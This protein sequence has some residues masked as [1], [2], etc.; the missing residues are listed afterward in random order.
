[1]SR[2]QSLWVLGQSPLNFFLLIVASVS[3]YEA[4]VGNRARNYF[5]E[6]R[7]LQAAAADIDDRTYDKDS[8]R[9]VE[10]SEN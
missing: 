3:E 2:W 9:N 6:W 10:S 4:G 7:F 1:M 5:I 8:G